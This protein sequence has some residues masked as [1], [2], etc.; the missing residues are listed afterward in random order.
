MIA[1]TLGVLTAVCV[2]LTVAFLG[3]LRGVVELRLQ[4]SGRVGTSAASPELIA[5]R[6]LPGALLRMLPNPQQPALIAFVSD[7]CSACEQMVALLP[8]IPVTTVACV[9]GKDSGEI[10]EHLGSE[11][12]VS[13]PA[14]AQTAARALKL[15]T[16]PVVLLQHAGR[17]MGSA[18]GMSTQT[19]DELQRWWDHTQALIKENAS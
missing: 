9:L 14:D 5:G 17:V 16:T 6:E 3:I 4:M 10:R 15:T 13:D 2:L 18:S 1:I 12:I 7:G 11:V 19:A 8:A